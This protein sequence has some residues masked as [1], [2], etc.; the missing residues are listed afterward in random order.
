MNRYLVF[1]PLL[2]SLLAGCGDSR[3][4]SPD[5]ARKPAHK[6]V[7]TDSDNGLELVLA[8]IG[9]T[10]RQGEECKFRVTVR[11]VTQ[12]KRI[13][14][15]R[16]YLH[17]DFLNS[18]SLRVMEDHFAGVVPS[19]RNFYFRGPFRLPGKSNF[20]PGPL[21][22]GTNYEGRPSK[23]LQRKDIKEQC[24][25]DV[26]FA[27]GAVKPLDLWPGHFLGTEVIVRI[28]PKADYVDMG[29]FFDLQSFGYKKS[30]TFLKHDEMLHGV[31]VL[32]GGQIPIWEGFL[33][34]FLK[35][36]D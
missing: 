17:P 19:W 35:I 11:N 20:A 28:P 22:L 21:F 5:C 10:F 12:D 6:L 24:V 30:L 33:Y 36:P 32:R 34:V 3:P 25:D 8:V 14:L 27:P 18:Q 31:A 29:I 1:G 26:E 2:F 13:L 16:F 7:G 23:E 4:P 15:P 9:G